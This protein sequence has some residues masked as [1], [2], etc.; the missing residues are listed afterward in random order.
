MVCAVPEFLRIATAVVALALAAWGLYCVFR[1]R[2]PEMSHVIGVIILEILALI[3]VG[4]AVVSIANGHKVAQMST[5]IG[6]IA[7][8]LI[9]PPA[10]LALAR[11]EPTKSGSAIIA[12]LGIVEAILVVRLQQVWTGI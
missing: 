12:V 8:F 1:N 10:G 5:F 6:Y 7:A 2:P 4:W 3:L 9:I 11:M